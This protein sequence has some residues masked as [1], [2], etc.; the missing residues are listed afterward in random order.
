MKKT[1][2]TVF[3]D[4]SRHIYIYHSILSIHII[5]R[6]SQSYGWTN[7]RWILPQLQVSC[8]CGAMT[9]KI[10]VWSWSYWV[11]FCCHPS[12]CWLFGCV[13]KCCVPLKPMVLL[14]IIPFL[15]GYFIGNIPYFQTNPDI[16]TDSIDIIRCDYISN[17]NLEGSHSIK[18][19]NKPYESRVDIMDC[20]F[21]TDLSA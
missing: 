1:W 7:A 16:I 8:W 15:N 6:G 18:C 12:T 17:H 21:F 19:I 13:W 4:I 2:F 10:M 3:T 14:I 9:V 20:G 5:H 11:G